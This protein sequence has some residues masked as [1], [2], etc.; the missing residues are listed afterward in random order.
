MINSALQTLKESL[1]K[2]SK[3]AKIYF[4]LQFS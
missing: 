3:A 1:L 2:G 4:Y